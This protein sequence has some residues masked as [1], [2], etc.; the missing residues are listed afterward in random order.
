MHVERAPPPRRSPGP[1]RWPNSEVYPWPPSEVPIR[2]GAS[3][4][5]AQVISRVKAGTKWMLRARTPN[6]QVIAIAPEPPVAVT[7]HVP[8]RRRDRDGETEDG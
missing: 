7:N 2:T 4:C 3:W 1:A 6:A 8:E 5:T